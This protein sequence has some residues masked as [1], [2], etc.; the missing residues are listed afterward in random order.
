MMAPQ[1]T[2]LGPPPPMMAP[3][4]FQSTPSTKSGPL[5]RPRRAAY[6]V[7]NTS[8]VPMGMDPT[9]PRNDSAP[10]NIGPPPT[11]GFRR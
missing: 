10:Q 11:G 2:D 8:N 1:K 5:G 6:P 9:A 7:Q 3:Q 4:T